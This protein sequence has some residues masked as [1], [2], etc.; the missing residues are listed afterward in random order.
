MIRFDFTVT[1]LEAETIMSIL[2]YEI[3]RIHV[4]SMKAIC[5]NDQA[6]IAY[7]EAHIK[8]LESIFAK[9]HSTRMSEHG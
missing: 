6:L 4:K 1:D 2:H 3:T 9:M 8:W 7:N 5:D